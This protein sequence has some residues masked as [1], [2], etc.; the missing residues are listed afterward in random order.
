MRLGGAIAT[1]LKY[2][3]T[4]SSLDLHDSEHVPIEYENVLANTNYADKC[5]LRFKPHIK[6]FQHAL[7]MQEV[8]CSGQICQPP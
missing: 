3:P 5:Y 8:H 6:A 7:C 2:V 4:F 1:F